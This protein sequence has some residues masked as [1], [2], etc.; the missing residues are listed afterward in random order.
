MKEEEPFFGHVDDS[1]V[2]LILKKNGEVRAFS[3]VCTHYGAPLAD[4][5]LSGNTL[6]CPW[7]H[8]RFCVE[9]G[10]VD[11][12]P[13]FNPLA[14]RSVMVEDGV[15]KVGDVVE[16]DPLSPRRRPPR[17][18]ETVII[19]GAGAA[20]ISAAE[21]LVREGYSGAIHL[22]D[23]DPDA[24]YDRP[25]L[26][27]DYLAGEA[28]EEW[29]PLR[30]QEFLEEHNISR[31]HSRV[32]S[33][34]LEKGWVVLDGDETL[35]FDALLLAPGA[36]PRKLDVP[37]VEQEHVFTLRSL[38]DCRSIISMSE[39]A[40]RAVVIGA[41]F[42]GTE[43]AASL[44]TRGLDVAVVAPEEV[45]FEPVLGRDL[46]GF[47]QGLHEDEGVRFHLGSTV[48]EI[49]QDQVVLENGTEIPA[50]LVVVGIGVEPRLELA[51]EAGLELDDGIVVDDFL[52]TSHPNVYAAGDVAF[53]PEHRL[54]RRVRVEH[55]VHAR[56][57]GRN[58]ALN[59]LGWEEP[60][61]DVPFFWTEHYGT[62]V[63]YVGHAEGWDEAIKKGECH[64]DGCSIAFRESGRV[65]ARATVYRDRESL[66]TEA[67]ME[68][69]GKAETRHP[70]IPA[71]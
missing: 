16:E 24:P 52:Q 57:Q 6:R 42:I 22:V 51:R 39:K 35:P 33:L 64:E 56:R 41:S 11:R 9:D 60:F 40:E 27:K 48:R 29:I 5:I 4:G 55:W 71:E 36:I 49:Q 66:E 38:A 53:Y 15:V 12:G 8:A 34:D 31:V 62:P 70:E 47:I 2:F 61:R 17:S 21:T 50:D 32:E 65:L 46:G 25:N 67:E 54:G 59:I 19:V 45:P 68:S 13:A 7:H 26:S 69:E 18:P 20:G 14:Q 63:A 43:V 30:S 28:P 10:A 3:A 58:V 1:P 23:P 37:G 44:R